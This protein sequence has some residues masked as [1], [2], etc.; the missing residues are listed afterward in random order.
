MAVLRRLQLAA[1]RM[2]GDSL[3]CASL[4]VAGL[5]GWGLLAWLLSGMPSVR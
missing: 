5:A 2:C 4:V 3:A 1:K